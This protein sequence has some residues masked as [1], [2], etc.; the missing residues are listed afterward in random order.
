MIYYLLEADPQL[1]VCWLAVSAGIAAQIPQNM[2]TLSCKNEIQYQLFTFK[3]CIF[4][5]LCYQNNLHFISL[6]A[7][8]SGQHWR[9]ILCNVVESTH[10]IHVK[11]WRLSFSC[12]KNVV[13]A[14][15]HPVY[16][17]IPG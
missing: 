12:K 6:P 9:I 8:W 10:C 5:L 17:K 13:E 4:R 16:S 1:W 7:V 15:K 14:Y 11:Q 2:Q 3:I